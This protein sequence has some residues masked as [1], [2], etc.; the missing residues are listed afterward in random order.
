MRRAVLLA[1]L[2]ASVS[3]AQDSPEGTGPSE[4]TGPP[5]GPPH[6]RHHRRPKPEEIERVRELVGDE[7]WGL[8]AEWR[9]RDVTHRYLRFLDA[10]PRQRAAIREAGL[11]SYLT[12]NNSRRGPKIPPELQKLIE[13]LS[14][15]QR[16]AAKKIVYVRMRQRR[17]DRNLN[18][19]PHADRLAWFER[20]FPEPF[21]PSTARAARLEFEKQVAGS[22]ANSLRPKIAKLKDL[23]DGERRT[24]IVAIVRSDTEKREKRL[25]AA[26]AKDLKRLKSQGGRDLDAEF[27]LIL[28]RG[29]VF[30]TPRQ[31]ELLRWAIRPGKCPLLDFGW[32]GKR[33][34]QR[35]AKRLWDRD[36]STLG[37]MDLLTKADFPSD[38]VLHLSATGSEADFLRAARHLLGGTRGGPPHGRPESP[39]PDRPSRRR[40]KAR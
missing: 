6:R 32:M 9:R 3:V 20:L 28:G 34:K 17:L 13:E 25:L 33:P 31:R 16:R 1:L 36:V 15:E 14:P 21:D 40:K 35:E 38:V 23:E 29:D 2:F 19:L 30:A 11:K 4:G 24:R 39:P 8:M 18:L 5:E 12:S 7:A 26:V 27:E 10:S 22:V 37:R